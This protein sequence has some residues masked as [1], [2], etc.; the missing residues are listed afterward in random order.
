MSKSSKPYTFPVLEID[1]MNKFFSEMAELNVTE[2]D[3]RKPQAALVQKLYKI[4]LEQVLDINVDGVCQSSFSN[5]NELDYPAVHE[6]SIYLRNFALA[7]QRVLSRCAGDTFTIRDL[8][9]P[10]AKPTRRY[11]SGLINF[12]YFS[13]ERLPAYEKLK[14][15]R[16]SEIE[17]VSNLCKAND[18]I[19]K[20]I[21]SIQTHRAEQAP[22]VQKG[23]AEIEKVEEAIEQYQ[24]QQNTIKKLNEEYQSKI[25]EINSIMDQKKLATAQLHEERQELEAKIVQSPDRMKRE[26]ANMYNQQAELKLQKEETSLRLIETQQRFAQKAEWLN[27]FESIS[28]LCQNLYE[29]V[30]NERECAQK[31][32][33]AQVEHRVHHASIQNL[34][35]KE[36]LLNQQLESKQNKMSKQRIL[37]KKKMAEIEEELQKLKIEEEELL[38]HQSKE[39]D[40]IGTMRQKMR[41]IEDKSKG[42]INQERE[43]VAKMKS[44]LKHLQQEVDS[45]HAKLQMSS[46]KIFTLMEEHAP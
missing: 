1:Q 9:D 10:K 42:K 27:D 5:L 28:R 41:E 19:K 34:L 14:N 15:E 37:H 22:D 3:L 26:Q 38:Q 8:V 13:M 45:Y 43:S 2:D 25:Q 36:E 46:E 7:L 32:T 4:C 23:E 30:S 12:Y 18:E 6:N 17:Q 35:R 44:K 33:K 24:R 31:F 21:N 20:K 16:E 11:L 29:Q 40:E 39:Q